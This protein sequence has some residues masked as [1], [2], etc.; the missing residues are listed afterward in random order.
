MTTTEKE[1]VASEIKAFHN[2]DFSDCP[3]LTDEQLSQLK[4][5]HYRNMANYKPIKKAVNIRID[6]D[7][8][9]WLK[10]EGMGYQTRL[11]TIL[12]NAMI[13]DLAISQES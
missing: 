2:T 11:N 8:L 6:A 5:S 1:R 9:E 12:R 10:E 7:I 13:A 4:P 3:E